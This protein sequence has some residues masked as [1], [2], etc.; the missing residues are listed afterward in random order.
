MSRPAAIILAIGFALSATEGMAYWW[1]H[2]APAGLGQPVLCYRPS[3]SRSAGVPPASSSPNP[4]SAIR[5]PQSSSPTDSESKIVDS[6]SKIADDLPSSL[7]DP[8]SPI[9]DPQSLIPTDNSPTF[10]PLPDI[11]DKAA[12]MLRC[13]GGQVFHVL[14][15]DS[16]G[17]HLAFFEWNQT[18][19]GSVLEAFRHMPDACL[20]SL[21]MIL[22]S[23][24]KTIPYQVA[25]ETLLF[26]HTIFR[27]PN[28]NGGVAAH[29][30]L[31]HA[32][33]A[34]WVSGLASVNSR[35]DLAGTDPARLRTIRLN[36]A[37]TR[38]HPS[39]AR[40]IQGTVRGAPNADL[41]WNAFE[42]TMLC[43]L[44]FETR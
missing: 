30:T 1:M 7:Q 4:Q 32:Y 28:P 6:G 11:Y 9:R 26:D 44:K 17:L 34:V 43:D 21:G 14:R 41:A 10:T 22:V 12:P 29:G 5:D 36:S 33:R 13:S 40:V 42:S 39:Y 2:P 31:V 16:L 27:D 15:G 24:E 20:G 18:D 37:L 35:G 23:K 8:Q 25:G 19:T 38:F 3:A